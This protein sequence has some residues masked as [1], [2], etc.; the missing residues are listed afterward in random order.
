MPIVTVTTF[1][2]ITRP[3]ANAVGASPAAPVQGWN[4]DD[5]AFNFSDGTNWYNA[6]GNL[7]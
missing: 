7:T 5:N 1:S 2:N 4:T 3:A 6:V